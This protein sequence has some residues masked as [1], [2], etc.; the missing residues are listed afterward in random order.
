MRKLTIAFILF[1]GL[2]LSCRPEAVRPNANVETANSDNSNRAVEFQPSPTPSDSSDINAKV[3]LAD[4]GS[5]G[6]GCLRTKNPNLYE[7]QHISVIIS[8]DEPP[9]KSIGATIEK[10]LEKSCARQFSESGDE[11]PGENV[12]Y[13]L[14]VNNTEEIPGFDVGIAVFEADDEVRIEKGS[15]QVDLNGDG[16]AEFFRKCTGFEGILF[17]VW[18]GKP[19]VGKRIWDSFYYLDYD[20]VPNCKK[21]DME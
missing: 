9:Q 18:S 7:K 4:V 8:L 14:K 3:G 15:A 2:L 1:A 10:K 16:T 20:T 12:F 13:S 19:L 21:K 6:T 17:T 11:N 5:E